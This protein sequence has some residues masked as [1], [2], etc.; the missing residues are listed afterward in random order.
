[1]T[2]VMLLKKENNLKIL[3][4]DSLNPSGH[5]NFNVAYI[6]LLAEVVDVTLYCPQN[7]YQNYILDE[8]VRIYDNQLDPI[9]SKSRFII[10]LFYIFNLY[11]IAQL[12][13]HNKYDIIFISSFD[14]VSFLFG[15]LFFNNKKNIYLFHHNNIDGLNNKIKRLFFNKYSRYV[16]HIVFEDFIKQRL[17]ELSNISADIV[18]VI[19]HPITKIFDNNEHKDGF[20]CIAISNSNNEL[21]LQDII[22]AQKK[23]RF[24][25][26]INMKMLIKTKYIQYDDGY[27]KTIS[28][29]IS[30]SEYD[31]YFAQC[32][33]FYMPFPSTF[34][35]RI[36]GTLIDALSNG[37]LVIG[38]DIPIL[39]Q[40]SLRYPEICI[41]ASSVE[42][43]VSLLAN[44]KYVQNNN[45]TNKFLSNHSKNNIILSFKKIFK[46]VNDV[47]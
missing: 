45:D 27:L 37:K 6:N 44:L 47:Y 4:A 9:N 12:C 15:F 35:Y 22:E 8:R 5:K 40:Y 16:K 30:V 29:F 2:V 14:T 21:L 43:F 10:Y 17:I 19:P 1:M 24:L 38:T 23:N 3:Y 25:E 13:N 34:Q 18:Y 31:S 46:G 39:R 36:S 42:E 33:I 26:Q 20:G 11:K 28:G 32:K 7:W 41:I